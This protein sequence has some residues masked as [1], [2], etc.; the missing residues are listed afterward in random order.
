MTRDKFIKTKFNAF[1]KIMH[2][3]PR[4]KQ[5]TVC[6]LAAVDFEEEILILIPLDKETFE[7]ITFEARYENCYIP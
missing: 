6:M 5:E 4:S 7:D 2:V 1:M 3:Q